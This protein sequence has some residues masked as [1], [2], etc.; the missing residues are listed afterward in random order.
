M[1]RGSRPPSSH[2][3][4]RCPS[5]GF[6]RQ[7]IL[8]HPV[9]HSTSTTLTSAVGMSKG[10]PVTYEELTPKYKQKFDEIKA[11]FEADL[12]GSFER[13]R[14]HGSRWKGFSPKGALDRVDL[15]LPSEEHTRAL[16]Q[17]VNYMVAHSLHRHSENLVHA[18]ERV[19]L[20]IVQE[21]M[22]NQYSP[23]GS[24]LGSHKGELSFQTKPPLPYAAAAPESHSAPAYV[25][26]KV[27]VTLEITSFSM[28]CLRKFHTGMHVHTYRTVAT[29]Y[30]QFSRRL[31]EFLGWMLISK[32]GWLSMPPGRAMITHTRP[33]ELK[34]R[35]RS[36]QS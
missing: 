18:F 8:A 4:C 31:G 1:D 21:I 25:V 16:C 33:Q 30:V 7:H 14:H 2:V 9:G 32:H 10:D 36:V 20:C 27:G 17:E 11:L 24:T 19:A 6:G 5:V 23:T 35:I 22:K 34:L 29:R 12:I 15:S 13:T 26:Y 28:S 3:A